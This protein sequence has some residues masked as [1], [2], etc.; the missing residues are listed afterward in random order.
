MTRYGIIGAVLA[1]VVGIAYFAMQAKQNSAASAPKLAPT[2]EE[3][4]P[5]SPIIVPPG[6]LSA[7]AAPPP[8]HP[9][10]A[11]VLPPAASALDSIAQ[12][13]AKA[14]APK[15]EPTATPAPKAPAAEPPKPA[16]PVPP[17]PAAKQGGGDNPY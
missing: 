13:S 14:P 17:K 3:L 12:P 10:P 15:V 7:L 1:L 5:P 4:A 2:G 8:E 9:H 11:P 16:P 6:V